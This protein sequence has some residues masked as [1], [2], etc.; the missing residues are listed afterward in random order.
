MTNQH[1]VCSWPS[2]FSRILHLQHFQRKS[3]R[4]LWL[5]LC[6]ICA[7]HLHVYFWFSHEL[8]GHD[9]SFR[10]AVLLPISLP[11]LGTNVRATCHHPRWWH[12]LSSPNQSLL[13][14]DLCRESHLFVQSRQPQ[15]WNTIDHGCLRWN[16]LNKSCSLL[17]RNCPT[18]RI[19]IL[20]NEF[21]HSN[22]WFVVI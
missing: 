3:L 7:C 2:W 21:A 13:I 10:H 14:F 16:Y 6:W 19:W 22:I 9:F 12:N 15:H 8:H 20:Q 18:I 1:Q 17:V 11:V 5:A 4:F